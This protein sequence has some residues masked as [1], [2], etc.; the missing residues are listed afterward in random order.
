[1]LQDAHTMFIFKSLI[2]EPTLTGEAV[3]DQLCANFRDVQMTPGT[4][5]IHMK[6]KCQL[7]HEH[8]VPQ[9]AWNSKET[10]VK[11]YNK[12]NSWISRK[13]DFFNNCMFIDEA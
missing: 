10:V 7:T 2:N 9:L 12:A 3:T 5:A 4:V 6:N 8:I 13:F 1:I 11:R